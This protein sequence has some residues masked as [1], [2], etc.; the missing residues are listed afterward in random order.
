MIKKLLIC[1]L[2]LSTFIA[3]CSAVGNEKWLNI[4]AITSRRHK[5]E[6]APAFLQ[7]SQDHTIPNDLIDQVVFPLEESL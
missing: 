3:L 1:T 4:R 2:L 5:N 7:A 6:Q